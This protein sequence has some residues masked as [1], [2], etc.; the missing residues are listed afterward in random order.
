MRPSTVPTPSTQRGTSLIEF[1]IVAVPL[2]LVGLGALEI[3]LW[4][5]T[6][7]A[8]SLALLQAGRAA[9]VDHANPRTIETAFE[10]A[11]LPLYTSTKRSS[12]QQRLQA[13]LE[14]RRQ[15]TGAAPWQIQQLSPTSAAFLDFRDSKLHVAG[16]TGLAV[17]NNNYLAE[18]HERHQ[19][20][21]RHY[22][23]GSLSGLNIFQANTLVLRLHWLHQPVVPGISGLLGLLG[24]PQGSYSQRAM[25][26]GYLPLS[27]DI[28]LVMQSHPVNWPPLANGKVI[29]QEVTPG[30]ASDA[31]SP[32]CTGIWCIHT[33]MAFGVPATPGSDGEL[34]SDP[35]T[36]TMP[37]DGTQPGPEPSP[38][39]IV[40][41][42]DAPA[43]DPDDMVCGVSL[44]CVD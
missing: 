14:Q 16:A 6:K 40:P 32:L 20:H 41:D 25:A 2:L 15:V 30:A 33:P 36:P 24:N 34:G 38:S 43:P 27:Q 18:Q 26:R 28:T 4:F 13:A 37:P 39:D 22:G 11:M 29:G 12:A 21:G 7:Q 23:R 42:V 9:I 19:Q 8:V 1:S 3:A 31:A 44:C 35:P 17:I 10:Q 5:F